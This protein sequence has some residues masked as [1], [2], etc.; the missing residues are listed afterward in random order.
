MIQLRDKHLDDRELVDRGRL[1]RKLTRGTNTLAIV[2]DRADI[3]AAVQADGVHLGQE[4]LSVKDARA[5]VGTR[6]LV[7]V[8]THNIEQARAAVLDG[9]NYLGAG[10]T[11]PS[12][13]KAFD[14]FAGLEFLRE[15]A[16]E[17]RLPTF[18]IGGIDAEN[19]PEV[20]AAGIER[21]AVSGA[22]T[23]KGRAAEAALAARE[24]LCMLK[25]RTAEAVSPLTSDL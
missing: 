17:I 7:G 2:N 15:M 6:M 3:A 25:S 24:L 4:D 14:A 10:P 13:T 18:A 16:A 5:I 9:A 11:F 8:S 1:L 21:V 20:L 23:G 19:L 12:R 22:V